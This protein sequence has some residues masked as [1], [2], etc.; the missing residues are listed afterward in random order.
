MFLYTL[1][2]FF[3]EEQF[4][5]TLLLVIGTNYS[6]VLLSWSYPIRLQQVANYLAHKGIFLFLSEFTAVIP[7]WQD[8]NIKK[9]QRVDRGIYSCPHVNC[10]RTF[11]W[12][13]NLKRHLTY[14]CGVLPRFKC[15]YCDYCCK[16]KSDVCKHINRRHKNCVVYVLDIF[17]NS[18]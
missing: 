3:L 16:V 12:K 9:I 10:R 11:K 14:E 6:L 18:S 5:I 15:P 2:I 7:P 4:H 17:K 13:G 8:L 1:Y